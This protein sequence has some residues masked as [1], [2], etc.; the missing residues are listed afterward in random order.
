MSEL[1]V[2][3][4]DPIRIQVN[5]G[6]FS[7]GDQAARL[8]V[9][10]ST[11]LIDVATMVKLFNQ[12]RLSVTVSN[13]SNQGEL[14]E[15]GQRIEVNA[16]VDTKSFSV[17]G[18][19]YSCGLT[20]ARDSIDVSQ[21][22]D[23]AK[24]EGTL[25]ITDCSA[26][27]PKQRHQDVEDGKNKPRGFPALE[28]LAKDVRECEL[29]Q[30]VKADGKPALSAND[31]ATLMANGL[32]TCEDLQKFIEK[33]AQY[34]ESELKKLKNFGT[35]KVEKLIDAYQMFMAQ[36][37]N[38]DKEKLRICND[39]QTFRGDGADSCPNCDSTLWTTADSPGLQENGEWS[40]DGCER[41]AFAHEGLTFELLI[42]EW[43]GGFYAGCYIHGYRGEDHCE[44]G[45]N[46]SIENERCD[47]E[48]AR[49]NAVRMLGQYAEGPRDDFGID[50]QPVLNH[51]AG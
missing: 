32:R 12:R 41:E 11:G 34:W 29:S 26:I 3:K 4:M 1:D 38:A 30:L 17:N 35:A 25:I 47:K 50:I 21:L 23:L 40:L 37:G 43:E 2:T 14:F 49:A 24:Q 10:I 16:D 46:P 15:D 44:Y 9:K 18:N 33:H 7:C 6:G 36:H 51:F 48:T 20:F 19:F 28:A 42:A 45:S 5:Y 31:C 39:C 22:A 27:P 13:E 8:G